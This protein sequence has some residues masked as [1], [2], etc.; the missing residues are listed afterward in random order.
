MFLVEEKLMDANEKIEAPQLLD[1]IKI[2]LKD[3]FIAS[4]RKTGDEIAMQFPNGQR[5]AVTVWED[6]FYKTK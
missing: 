2:L 6:K 5:F 4:V 1:E 3:D